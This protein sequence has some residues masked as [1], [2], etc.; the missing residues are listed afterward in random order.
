[1]S[2]TFP[3]SVERCTDPIDEACKTE[4][5]MRENDIALARAKSAPEQLQLPTLGEDGKPLLDERGVMIMYWPI[6][7]CVVCD[8]PIPLGRLALARIRCVTCQ[9]I[10]EKW[11][12]Q[13]G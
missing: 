2:E 12:S 4:T 10:L 1:M 3:D 5:R 9:G 7:E 13:H 8:E 6:T 11:N